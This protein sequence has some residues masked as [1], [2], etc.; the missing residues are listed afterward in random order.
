MADR[1]L[2]G[3][4]ISV[5]DFS[6]SF[7]GIDPNIL[8]PGELARAIRR[9]S[10]WVNRECRQILY[11]TQDL[12]T[13][14]YGGYPVGCTI[15][16]RTGELNVFPHNFPIKKILSA[17]T[18]T[19][20]G[21]SPVA[22]YD[23]TVN[24]VQGAAD[25]YQRFAKLQGDARGIEPSVGGLV[26]DLTYINGYAV[27]LLA[28]PIVASPSTNQATL[29]PQP[30]QATVQG[31]LPGTAVEFQDQNTEIMTVQSVAGNVVT[32]TS[33]FVDNH[34]A[35][36]MVCETE[37]SDVQQATLLVTSYYIKTRGLSSL[38]LRDESVTTGG[39]RPEEELLIEARELLID[40]TAG[41]S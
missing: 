36:T 12:E 23:S 8:Q 13:L 18:R 37:L 4:Y 22:W 5:T 15:D 6:Q 41:Q 31:F 32:F 35:D 16:K 7:T 39:K 24:P 38:A 20:P 34:L 40:F 14:I 11:A 1:T 28:S 25:I 3:S 17:K 19:G 9:A 33:N 2:P 27:A 26:T 29:V 10:S 21:S 30:G